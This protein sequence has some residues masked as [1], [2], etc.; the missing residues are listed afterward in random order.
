MAIKKGLIF[1][2][3]LTFAFSAFGVQA[4]TTAH[5]GIGTVD[6]FRN[7]G[8]GIVNNSAMIYNGYSRTADYNTFIEGNRTKGEFYG[9]NGTAVN[10]GKATVTVNNNTAGTYAAADMNNDAGVTTRF[11]NLDEHWAKDVI[12]DFSEGRVFEKTQYADQKGEMSRLDAIML[13]MATTD[14]NVTDNSQRMALP[15]ADAAD[16]PVQYRPIV[17]EAYTRGIIH[18]E[19]VGSDMYLYPNRIVTHAELT[20]ML[21]NAHNMEMK[22]GGMH[23][24]VGTPI[25]AHDAYIELHGAGVFNESSTSAD[26]MTR[27][28]AIDMIYDVVDV[29]NSGSTTTRNNPDETIADEVNSASERDDYYGVETTPDTG[30]IQRSDSITI[31]NNSENVTTRVKNVPANE[32]K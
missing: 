16:V 21:S 31:T 7:N 6:V 32:L 23:N 8:T 20:T 13:V 18:G 25:W 14:E 22:K 17:E 3:V 29:N 10:S 11:G 4:S 24:V 26:R 1:L 19:P 2:I 28:N 27:T 30:N 9:V 5:N 15:F 12:G